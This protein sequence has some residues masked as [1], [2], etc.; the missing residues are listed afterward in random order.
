MSITTQIKM[1]VMSDAWEIK[2]RIDRIENLGH[3]IEKSE[4]E[5]KRCSNDF[6]PES[7]SIY[8]TLRER[9]RE[10]VVL[11]KELDNHFGWGSKDKFYK[12]RIVTGVY[13]GILNGLYEKG[14]R[15]YERWQKELDRDAN[16]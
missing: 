15:N 14:T 9:L 4:A 5:V 11:E 16:M 6:S 8:K 1:T 7:A 12:D 13:D 2:S 3:L 10:I